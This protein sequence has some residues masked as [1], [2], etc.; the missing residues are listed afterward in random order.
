KNIPLINIVL[1]VLNAKGYAMEFD[2]QAGLEF[3]EIEGTDHRIGNSSPPSLL[4]S[5]VADSTAQDLENGGRNSTRLF[6]RLHPADQHNDGRLQAM[7]Q[8]AA[9]ASA[10]S[11]AARP[12]TTGSVQQV[13][14]RM[15]TGQNQPRPTLNSSTSKRRQSSSRL[16]HNLT[17]GSLRS[18]MPT[19]VFECEDDRDNCL[20]VYQGAGRPSSPTRSMVGGIG[21]ALYYGYPTGLSGALGAALSKLPS[22]E[23]GQFGHMTAKENDMLASHGLSFGV[24]AVKGRRPYMEDEFKV[25]PNLDANDGVETGGGG[26]QGAEPTHFFGMFDGHAG[27]RCSKALTQ[28]LGQT[29]AREPDF[30]LELASAVTKGFLR[31]NND[32]LRKAERFSAN[33]GSTAITVFLRGRQLVVGN[34]G[35][36]RAVLCSGRKAVPLSCDHKPNKPEE[37]RRIQALG[38][39]VIYSFGIPRVNGILAVSRAFGDRNMKGSINAD[40]DVKQRALERGD[41]Y[42]I[43]ATDGLWDV[44]TSQEAC[45]IV[46]NCG[47]DLGPQAC[48]ELLTAT[49]LRKGSMDNTS[50]MVV[51]LR[52]VLDAVNNN[53]GSNY[54]TN[55]LSAAASSPMT[56]GRASL[57]PPSTGGNTAGSAAA[58]TGS[59]LRRNGRAGTP[60]GWVSQ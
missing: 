17:L 13:A 14:R 51:D 48:S 42:L 6:Q 15:S 2:G 32:F 24:S 59:T 28:I 5:R 4:V 3:A 10:A 47:S 27:G 1:R 50:A 34:V 30:S 9:E 29:V 53:T 40:P 45:N 58:A 12:K 60:G 33:D 55:P 18:R 39:R 22:L 19:G 31:A 54:C 11:S 37:R 44:V 36:S 21:G 52:G 26:R 38:G 46:S 57:S 41:E 8:F 56:S 49:A 35:D 7:R 43:L 16:S 25:I 23:S 20:D